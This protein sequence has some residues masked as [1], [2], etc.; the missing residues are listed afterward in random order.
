MKKLVLGAVLVL[1]ITIGAGVFFLLSNLDDLVKTAIET[2]GSQ[3]T[4]TAVR[5]DSVKI[6]LQDGSGAIL[7][8]QVG[9]PP[10]FETPQA[11][12]LGEISLQVDLQSLSNDAILIENV[13]VLAPEVFFELNAAGKANLNELKRALASGS[14]GSAA[15][16]AA[17][18]PG[19]SEPHLI[20]RKLLF[21]DGKIHARVVP[22]NKDYELKLPKI[23]LTDLGGPNGA[24]PSQIAEQV[25]KILTN[26]ALAEIE[27]Q[28][29][30][31]YQ[32]KLEGEVNK[33]LEAETL[34][35]Q[36]KINDKVGEQVGGQLGD[37]VKGLFKKK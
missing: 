28:G 6:G 13:R 32:K 7:G 26:K 34:K 19:G 12:S 33:R 20:I 22:L 25:L 36:Q 8:L 27:K 14:A 15:A 31:Q 16:P 18:T 21:A 5:V 37:A 2:Y 35:L 9:N 1:L 11:F 3:A 30:D 4:R 17:S 23:E 29:L 24:T 10:G